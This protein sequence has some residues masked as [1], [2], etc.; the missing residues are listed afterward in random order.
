VA[1]NCDVKKHFSD[2]NLG[3]GLHVY[4]AIDWA[5]ERFEEVIIL[6]DDCIAS[7]SFFGYCQGL[8]EYYRNDERVMHISGNNFLENAFPTTYSYYFSK[9]THAWGWATWRRAWK[10]FD[11]KME[12]W[13]ECRD[14]DIVKSWCDDPLERRYWQGVF[15]KMHGGRRDVWDYQWN[16]ACWAQNGLAILPS[17]NLVSNIG[18][19]QDATHTRDRSPY[20][21]RSTSD[22][23]S[24]VH[25]PVIIRN[26][27]ADAL[28]FENNFGGA[29][30]KYSTTWR[31]K[32]RSAFHHFSL[33]YRAMRK[34]CR[35]VSSLAD[36]L[37]RD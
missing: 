1:W 8:L 17:V 35:A 28:T 7:A 31:A 10:Y 29:A 25:P 22:I 15:D 13:P 33:P 34:M 9:Y 20:L 3:C 12:R 36:D 24:L 5:L 6:E 18:H 27:A 16:F 26:L 21:E 30:M 11:W 4:S 23:Q 32:C 19:G 2:E 37:S 14:S